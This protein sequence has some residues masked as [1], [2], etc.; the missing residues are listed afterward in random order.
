[1]Q[2]K[3]FSVVVRENGTLVLRRFAGG[4]EDLCDA[5]LVDEEDVD[6]LL[7]DLKA[8]VYFAYGQIAETP[9]PWCTCGAKTMQGEYHKPGCP[10]YE[11]ARG[12]A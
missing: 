6:A 8:H 1:M 4:P 2:T 5:Q 11:R 12:R 7:A 3:V 9:T 10:A